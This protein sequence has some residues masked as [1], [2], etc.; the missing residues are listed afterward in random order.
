MPP[1][2]SVLPAVPVVLAPQGQLVWATGWVAMGPALPESGCLALARAQKD[3][4]S[5]GYQQ[6]LYKG[7]RGT[8]R[9]RRAAGAQRGLGRILAQSAEQSA[10]HSLSAE[11]CRL[12]Q[13]HVWRDQ[14]KGTYSYRQPPPG[15]HHCFSPP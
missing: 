8:G 3:Q 4:D 5:V 14:L 15:Q 6:V 11:G 9:G 13:Q 7:A 1:A 2:H 12:L 10:Q